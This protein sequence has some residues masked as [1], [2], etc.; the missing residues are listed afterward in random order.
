MD[1][2]VEMHPQA[3]WIQALV[4]ARYASGSISDRRLVGPLQST[5]QVAPLE[6]SLTSHVS[7]PT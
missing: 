6:F 3:V 2:G 5:V 1:L 4:V 7:F